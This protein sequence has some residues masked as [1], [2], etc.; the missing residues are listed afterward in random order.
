M[1]ATGTWVVLEDP[2]EKLPESKIELLDGTKDAIRQDADNIESNV[3]TILS[4]G[5]RV[6]DSKI[7][8]GKKALLDPRMPVAILAIDDLEEEFVLVAQENQIMGVL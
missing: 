6:L 2:R 5:E 7:V 4:V 3:L 1:K 8:E